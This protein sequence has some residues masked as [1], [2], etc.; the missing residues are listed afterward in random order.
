MLVLTRKVGESIMIGDNIRVTVTEIAGNKARVG[1]DAPRDVTVD[2]QEVHERRQAVVPPAA[3]VAA[4]GV[5][6]TPG[7]HVRN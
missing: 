7:A 6:P 5:P 3:L 4:T 2:R 1:V